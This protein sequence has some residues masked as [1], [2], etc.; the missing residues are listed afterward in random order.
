MSLHFSR[1]TRRSALAAAAVVVALASPVAQAQDNQGRIKLFGRRYSLI[2][3]A[4]MYAPR[5]AA[6]RAIYGER[7]FMPS[8]GLWSFETRHGVGFSW[9][10]GGQRMTEGPRRAELLHGGVGPRFQFADASSDFAPYLAL[11]GDGY[12]MRLDRGDWKVKP[13]A[14]VELGA[15]I[16]RHLVISVRYDAVPKIGGI[17]LSGFGARAAVKLF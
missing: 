12:G 13:G 5:E 2:A 9:D 4:S 17:D 10:F 16:L 7:S 3:G 6:T 1:V 14:N 11:R 15:S 8:L